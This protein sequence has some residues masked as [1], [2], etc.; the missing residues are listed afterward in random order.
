MNF[1][2]FS[3]RAVKGVINRRGV[4]DAITRIDMPTLIIVGEEDVATVPEKSERMRAAIGGSI[5]VKIP[6]AGHSSTIEE[7]R[8]VNDA[9]SAFLDGLK[10]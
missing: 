4:S 1:C 3:T 10:G 6:R 8:A 7:P 9:M 2:I 5:L